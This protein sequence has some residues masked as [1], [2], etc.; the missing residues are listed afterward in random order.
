MAEQAVRERQRGWWYPWLLSGLMLV[1][2]AVNGVMIYLAVDTFTGLE[3]PDY[4]R[5]GIHYNDDIEAARRQARLGWR[6]EV[7]FAADGTGRAAHEG[8]VTVDFSDRESRPVE[9]LEVKAMFVRPTQAGFDRT[10]TLAPDGDGRYAARIAL[11]LPG[12]WQVRVVARRDDADYQAV[13]RIL[14]P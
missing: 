7:A 3:T 9:G 1:V 4:Y 14:V 11:P 10:V 13:K 5:K 6:A 2:V 8:R 12:Q